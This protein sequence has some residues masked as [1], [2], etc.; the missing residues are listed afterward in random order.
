MEEA[1]NEST[2]KNSNESSPSPSDSSNNI[3]EQVYS[4]ADLG[5]IYLTFEKSI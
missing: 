1:V 2:E 5:I 3:D 4:A